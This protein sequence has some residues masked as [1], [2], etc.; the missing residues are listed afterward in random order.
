MEKVRRGSFPISSSV[1]KSSEAERGEEILTVSSLRD[2]L[3]MKV[4][5]TAVFH[6]VMNSSSD[7]VSLWK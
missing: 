6:F 3:E 5:P 1:I 4:S 7:I 2:V